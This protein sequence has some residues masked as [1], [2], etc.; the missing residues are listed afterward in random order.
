MSWEARDLLQMR[1]EL[2]RLEAAHKRARPG[3]GYPTA[4]HYLEQAIREA[5]VY[6]IAR[7]C[8]ACC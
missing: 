3:Y 2:M 7:G 5:A 4:R 8:H 6:I 1:D